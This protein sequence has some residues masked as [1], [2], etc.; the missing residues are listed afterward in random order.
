LELELELEAEAEAEAEVESEVE[1][2][3]FFL[4]IYLRLLLKNPSHLQNSPKEQN[5]SLP[6]RKYLFENSGRESEYFNLAFLIQRKS[7]LSF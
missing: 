6:H 7:S 3:Q 4:L 2:F 1:I 5:K